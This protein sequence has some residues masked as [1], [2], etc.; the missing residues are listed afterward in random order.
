[1]HEGITFSN[2]WNC[3][4]PSLFNVGYCRI[5]EIYDSHGFCYK[6]MHREIKFGDLQNLVGPS[7]LDDEY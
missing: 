5:K 7:L 6:N 1:M 2:E 3:V 4:G